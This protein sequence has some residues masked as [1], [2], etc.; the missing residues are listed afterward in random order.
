MSEEDLEAFMFNAC[1]TSWEKKT[2]QASSRLQRKGKRNCIFF[3]LK[4]Y[5]RTFSS[6]HILS[7]CPKM[8]KGKNSTLHCKL[9]QMNLF[10]I[11]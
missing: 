10:I 5:G 3:S 9:G 11:S 2:K 8:I 7:V 4:Y 6:W 1:N